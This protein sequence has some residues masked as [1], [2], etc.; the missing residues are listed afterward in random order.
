MAL[1]SHGAPPVRMMAQW[2]LEFT[3]S[4]TVTSLWWA[5]NEE[6]ASGEDSRMMHM[7]NIHDIWSVIQSLGLDIHDWFQSGNVWG[8][9]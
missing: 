8:L 3:L 5:S 7:P 2:G 4:G 9:V 1:G 6:S